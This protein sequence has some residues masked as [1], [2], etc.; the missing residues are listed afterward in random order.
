MYTWNP[1]TYYCKALNATDEALNTTETSLDHKKVTFE[2]NNCVVYAMSL[3]LICLLSSVFFSIS[4]YY[5]RLKIVWKKI[6]TFFN[7]SVSIIL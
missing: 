3:V 7:L 5:T 1:T 4:C 2:K 6:T